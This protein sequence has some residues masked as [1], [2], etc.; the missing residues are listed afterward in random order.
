M[1]W[2]QTGDV[3]LSMKLSVGVIG[4]LATG[5]VGGMVG[6]AL[7]RPRLLLVYWAAETPTFAAG[8]NILISSVSAMSGAWRHYRDGRVD[9]NVFTFMGIPAFIGAFGG[10]FLGGQ[11]P[12]GYL[13]LFVA[14]TT[15]WFGYNYLVG[16]RRNRPGNPSGQSDAAAVSHPPSDGVPLAMR[17]KEM[18]LG[19][20]IGVL[21]GIVGLVLGQLRLP[22]MTEVLKLDPK[23]AAGTN[24]AIATFTGIF[25]FAGH[26]VHREVDWLVLALLAPAAMIGSYF[27]A[28]YTGKLSGDTLKRW[29]GGVM[30]FMSIPLMWIAFR[31][32]G[33]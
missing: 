1:E 23:I 4:A 29:M 13:M 26:L 28:R 21:G 19:F 31:Q 32:I 30:V 20:G 15:T 12:S 8:T 27:G 7:G 5:F 10:G 14:L 33:S 17:M 25:G 2:L 3:P 11:V 18:M 22:A 24:L 16:R 9:L 6:L